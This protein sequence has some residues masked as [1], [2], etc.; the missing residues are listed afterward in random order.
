MACLADIEG[1]LRTAVAAGSYA[2]AD[3]LLRAYRDELDRELERPRG[4]GAE[5]T[6][7][8]ALALLGWVR[9]SALCGRAQA[10]AQL[11][12]LSAGQ[13]YRAARRDAH[14]WRLEI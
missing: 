2:A 9:E 8:E 11:R 1:R 5:Q 6:V 7:A 14:T 10:A 13:A 3:R 12:E 4:A